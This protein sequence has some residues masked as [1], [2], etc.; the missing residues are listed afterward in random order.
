MTSSHGHGPGAPGKTMTLNRAF[1]GGF[2][3][4]YALVGLVGFAVSGSVPFAGQEGAS[5]LGFGV[6]GLH[7]IVHLLVGAAL[8]AGFAGGHAAARSVNLVVGAVYALLAIGGPFINDTAVDLFGLNGADHLLHLA[9][10]VLLLGVAL[11]G[12][13]AVARR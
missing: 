11:A 13:K 1:A 2:G 5:L 3:A 6:N 4:V 7:N 9:T 8:L 10:A 12:D